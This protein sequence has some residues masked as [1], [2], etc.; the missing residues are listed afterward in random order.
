MR[1][2]VFLLGVP[3]M[4][5]PTCSQGPQQVIAVGSTLTITVTCTGLS[6]S[7][8]YLWS[9]QAPTQPGAPTQSL[10]FSSTT[11]QTVNITGCVFGPM[12]IRVAVT[13]MSG[14]VNVDAH[15]GCVLTDPASNVVYTGMYATKVGLLL[16]PQTIMDRSCDLVGDL[17]TPTSLNPW[18]WGDQLEF[19]WQERYGQAQN[20]TPSPNPGFVS[21][22]KDWETA[23]PGTCTFTNGSIAVTC[24]GT[25]L[26]TSFCGSPAPCS[27]ANYG[28]LVPWYP[29]TATPA[30]GG[31][32]Y[33]GISPLTATTGT[34]DSPWTLATCT[35]C[36]FSR[37]VSSSD[38][39]H[40][41]SWFGG[42]TNNNYY[43]DV[44][45]YYAA[46][47]R[48]GIEDFLG[49]ARW[50]ADAWYANPYL[51]QY[52]CNTSASGCPMPRLRS[53]EGI[54]LR[55]IDEDAVAGMT[56]ASSKWPNIRAFWINV[57]AVG[58]TLEA[59]RPILDL[60]EESYEMAE[61]ALCAITN[62]D[63]TEAQT[64]LVLGDNQLKTG[65]RWQLQRHTDVYGP[66]GNL[67]GSFGGPTPTL[68]NNT[69]S[70]TATNGSATITLAGGTW[71]AGN[72]CNPGSTGYITMGTDPLSGSGWDQRG[73][74]TTFVDA[75]HASL[76]AVYAGTTGSGKTWLLNGH[77]CDSNGLDWAG[78]ITQPFMLGITSNMMRLW[79]YALVNSGNAAP[80]DAATSSTINGTYLPQIANWLGT[81][82]LNSDT[83]MS[84]C[85]PVSLPYDGPW[86]GVGGAACQSPYGPSGNVN[87][88]YGAVTV[89][90]SRELSPELL[91][92]IS[93]AYCLAPTNN[94]L[95]YGNLYYSAMFAKFTGEIGYDGGWIGL[96]GSATND[97]N[98]GSGF[99]WPRYAGKWPG[100]FW[101][102]GRN[103]AWLS[104]RQG[105]QVSTT[106]S[107]S[108]TGNVT[109]S[110]RATVQ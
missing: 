40:P 76:D 25:N 58:V 57:T 22:V 79:A 102:Y 88:C 99:W 16:G 62:P 31:R 13:D 36:K 39:T 83:C 24:S 108:I 97:F 84:P 27:P 94:L 17:C 69:G 64:C 100:F 6:G 95:T 2:L 3:L 60:R 89:Q 43:D 81:A 23:E 9:Y 32:R 1:L 67:Y 63:L 98:I 59:N 55:A 33:F 35:G 21:F 34:L 51:D 65:G 70:I 93:T 96:P 110:G 80:F 71:T 10:M 68:G 41:Q 103:Q 38:A 29:N 50:L 5:A 47:Y 73:Y 15:H 106:P 19:A 72:F 61:L 104:A 42:S 8:S 92:A 66:W 85:V 48:T 11:T 75:T 86:Y 56:G 101:G 7:P 30:T 4:A 52:T 54:V 14:T 45:S 91:N 20:T 28:Y 105:C 90:Q 109:I 26:G 78:Q 107:T 82:A 46:Y 53:L 77:A 74:I 37:W 49:Y 44:K 18:P 12:N 87:Q